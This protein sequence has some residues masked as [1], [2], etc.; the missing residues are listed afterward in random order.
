ML[1][2][3][4]KSHVCNLVQFTNRLAGVR[5][6]CTADTDMYMCVCMGSM[7]SA[8]EIVCNLEGFRHVPFSEAQAGLITGSFQLILLLPDH[9]VH[10][11]CVFAQSLGAAHDTL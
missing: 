9:L 4:Y 11:L 1:L 2:I 5:S 6:D 7:L 10:H 8:S 3:A